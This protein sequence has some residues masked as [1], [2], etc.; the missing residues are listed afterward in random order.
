MK[1]LPPGVKPADFEAALGEFRAAVGAD[2]VFSADEDVE[3][4][5]D[6]FSPSWGEEDERRASAAVAP[7]SVEEVQAIV[8]IANRRRIPLFPISTGRNFGYGGPAPNL[9]GTVVIDLKRM[10]KVIEVDDKRHFCIVE[11]GVSYLDLYRHIQERGLKVWIDCPDPG[12]GSPVGNALDH[13]VGYTPGIHRDHFGAHCGME[14][15]LANGEVMRTGMGAMPGSKTWGEYRYGYGPYVDGLFAQG[16]FGIVT[17]M[18]F[19]LMPE[20]E[21]YLTSTVTVPRHDDL[22]ALI[23]EMNYLEHVGVCGDPSYASPMGRYQRD[24]QLVALW[25][26][27]GRASAEELDAYAASKGLPS[28]SARLQFYGSAAGIAADFEYAKARLRARLPGAQFTPAETI[29]FPASDAEKDRFDRKV[30]IGVPSL[31]VFTGMALADAAGHVYFTSVIPKSAE[32][33]FEAQRVYSDVYDEAGV[34][35]SGL[36]GVGPYSLPATWAYHTFIFRMPLP[37]FHD[38]VAANRKVRGIIHKLVEVAA[39]H[40]WGEY[41]T[42]AMFQDAV[43]MAYSFN[44]NALLHFCEQ[45]KDAVDPNGILAPGRGGVWPK[46]LRKERK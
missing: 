15:V 28:W 27:P 39:A 2:W 31:E 25:K 7:A 12:W 10:N 35:F 14:V 36:A 17:K 23:E 8:R 24:P 33:V 38:D 46:H 40:G 42:P 43:A 32:A 41:R 19:W 21:A 20:P 3:L 9:S 6:Q 37:T 5:R 18:G 29:R 26:K 30:A 13:G 34:Q 45:I 22:H 44:N 11:P 16:N 4:Y 1:V